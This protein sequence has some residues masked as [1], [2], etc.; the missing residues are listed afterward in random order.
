MVRDPMQ[1]R[2]EAEYQ[3]LWTLYER[4]VDRA[5]EVIWDLTYGYPTNHR[6]RALACAAVLGLGE[7]AG[8]YNVGVS[9]LR[10]WERQLRVRGIVL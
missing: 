7:A 9:S 3:R 1:S 10:R 8:R 6:F 5:G 4:H 2:L